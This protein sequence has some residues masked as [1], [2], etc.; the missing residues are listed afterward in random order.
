MSKQFTPRQQQLIDAAKRITDER[1]RPPTRVELADAMKLKV[2]AVDFH[3]YKLRKE[4]T[5]IAIT[6]D[7]SASARKTAEVG[8]KRP[9]PIVRARSPKAPPVVQG[10]DAD[11]L[12]AAMEDGVAAFTARL[13]AG[14][15]SRRPRHRAPRL[16]A[17]SGATEAATDGEDEGEGPA[18]SATIVFQKFVVDMVA[19]AV[20]TEVQAEQPTNTQKSRRKRVHDVRARTIGLRQLRRLPVLGD[21]PEPEVELPRRPTNRSECRD[22]PRPCPWV[23]CR[24]HLYLD[25]SPRGGIRMVFPDLEPHEMT[26]SCS[27]DVADRGS[28]TLEEV[29]ACTNVT[30]ERVRQ[31]EDKIKRRLAEDAPELREFLEGIG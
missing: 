17:R 5:T 23:G 4:D 25:V 3:L 16:P 7:A 19:E 11:T 26:E 6:P 8:A 14:R 28:A 2:N 18:P 24:H 13:R 20:Q 15:A 12:I 22:G 10:V 29:G 1:G 21:A 27:I 9:A 31:I 30:R